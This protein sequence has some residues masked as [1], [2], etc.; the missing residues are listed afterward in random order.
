MASGIRV[1]GYACSNK[2]LRSEF[3]RFDLLGLFRR[4]HE[5]LWLVDSELRDKAYA[6]IG[7]S[8]IASGYFSLYGRHKKSIRDLD[9]GIKGNIIKEMRQA[10]L[11]N[12]EE[13]S[14]RYKAFKYDKHCFNPYNPIKERKSFLTFQKEKSLPYISYKKES[15]MRLAQV[16]NNNIDHWINH[17]TF[18]DSSLQEDDFLQPPE[19]HSVNAIEFLLM[20]PNENEHYILPTYI[21]LINKAKSTIHLS[22]AFFIPSKA[23]KQSLILAAKR[24]VKIQIITNS[25]E[26]NEMPIHT[27]VGRSRYIDFYKGKLFDQ[28]MGTESQQDKESI[29]QKI[30]IWEFQ[31]KKENDTS[32]SR[33]LYHSKFMLVDN[34]VAIVGS[35]NL[36]GSSENN[37]ESAVVFSGKKSSSELK[38]VFT[39]DLEYSKKISQEEI[40]ANTKPRKL[41]DRIK[42]KILQKIEMFL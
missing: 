7:G 17:N 19:Y 3:R 21:S 5:K 36:T 18:I 10:F 12:M 1:F 20:R 28:I 42:L 11:T 6:I 26:S 25:M 13:K 34:A 30:E 31:G 33:G 39:K 2:S 32:Y 37:S 4:N 9:I 29:I 15:N 35:Y 27:I 24:G 40:Q 22:N 14:F 8:N 16:V 38:K 23:F 41:L